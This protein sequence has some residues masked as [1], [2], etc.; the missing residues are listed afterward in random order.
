VLAVEDL[1]VTKSSSANPGDAFY[2]TGKSK[3]KYWYGHLGYAPSVG[4]EFAKGKP[5][6]SIAY[7][8]AP[9][10]HLGIDARDLCGRTLL[11]GASGHGPDY[12]Y[13]SP[14]VGAQLKEYLS[15]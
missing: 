12:T 11:Y 14:T 6:G 10:V 8:K 2:A 13:G 4:K 1:I 5:V 15:L 9:H 3:L 7:Q